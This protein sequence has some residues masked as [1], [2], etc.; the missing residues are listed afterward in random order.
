MSLFIIIVLKVYEKYY[1]PY[2]SLIL[3][4]IIVLVLYEV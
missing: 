3:T 4:N 2:L 1:N